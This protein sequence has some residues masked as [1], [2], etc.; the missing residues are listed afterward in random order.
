M[1]R[2]TKFEADL[3][4]AFEWTVLP[5]NIRTALDVIRG[6]R[7]PHDVLYSSARI[8]AHHLRLSGHEAVMC[9]L[10]ILLGTHGVEVLGGSLDA[11]GNT[12]SKPHRFE[13]LNTGDS[14]APTV[15]WYRSSG[16]FYI[17]CWADIVESYRLK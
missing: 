9:C 15:V 2:I 3:R 16:R 10:D 5:E 17:R 1:P 6:K 7:T 4:Q 13:Y 14:Y 12:R 11:H 8:E